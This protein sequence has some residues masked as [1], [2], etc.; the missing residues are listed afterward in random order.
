[1]GKRSD[2]KRVA[3][4]FYETPEHAVKPLVPF[5]SNVQSYCEPCAGKGA[6]ISHLSEV[7]E[8]KSAYDILPYR[9]FI[10]P[11]DAL[12]LTEDHL[13]KAEVIITNPPWNRKL[14]HPLIEHFVSLRPTWLLFDAD[15]IH[16]QQSAPYLPL[17]R[18]IVSI[19]RVKW[20]DNVHGKDNSCWYLFERQ[21]KPN[22]PRFYGRT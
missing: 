6:L 11:L 12:E 2:F 8:C 15:W 18:K 3:R 7:L 22:A 5:L 19:G 9:S 4:D 17:L 10:H 21:S 16:T 1:M 20:F 13:K 14:L